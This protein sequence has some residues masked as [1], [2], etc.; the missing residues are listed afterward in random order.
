MALAEGLQNA[1]WALGGAPAEHRTDSL[2]AAFRNLEADHPTTGAEADAT[3][4][5]E[6]PLRGAGS[7]QPRTLCR[8]YGMVA[9]RNKRG[10][11]HE[12]GAIEGPHGHLERAIEDALLLR[13]V[14]EFD[15]LDAYRR[16]LDELVGR[17]NARNPPG[18]PRS[19]LRGVAEN[20]STPSAPPRSGRRA[21]DGEEALIT[22]TGIARALSPSAA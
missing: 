2:S 18:S 22:V 20:A 7:P 21:A 12:N 3:A 13:G 5:Y 6:A 4:R 1:L 9:T 10:V 16:F 17:R 8:H 15:D 11:A 14:P 19:L